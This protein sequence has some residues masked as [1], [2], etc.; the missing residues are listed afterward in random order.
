MD[1]CKEIHC[2]IFI[3]SMKN[4]KKFYL[5]I[6]F[7]IAII[8]LIDFPIVHMLIRHHRLYEHWS[9]NIVEALL[10]VIAL[11]VLIYIHRLEFKKQ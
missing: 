5:G 3:H 1:E 6:I 4:H 2:L 7:G 11:I 8:A 10:S 9:V